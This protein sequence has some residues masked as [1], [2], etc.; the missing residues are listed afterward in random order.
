MHR[1]DACLNSTKSNQLSK[2]AGFSNH[3]RATYRAGIDIAH[4][5]GMKN[6]ILTLVTLFS[7]SAASGTTS[8]FNLK[9]SEFLLD[10][11]QINFD[12]REKATPD[13]VCD[14]RPDIQ[15]CI[16]FVAGKY[17]TSENRLEAARACAG[18]VGVDCVTFVAGKYA[19]F[20]NRIEAANSC[21]GTRELECVKFVAGKYATLENRI[22]SAKSCRNA[23][24]ACVRHV[25]GQY[26]TFEAR[27]EAAEACGGN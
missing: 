13:P 26:A 1:G 15:A 5:T 2:T 25:A 27:V 20:E 24:E 12:F 4:A 16:A 8:A 19:T 9:A 10:R 6:K 18:F 21:K 7:I 14:P 17:A 3:T 22:L 23:E 11:S